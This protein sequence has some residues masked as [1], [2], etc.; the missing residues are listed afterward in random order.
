MNVHKKVLKRK[1]ND[2]KRDEERK[3]KLKRI[4]IEPSPDGNSFVFNLSW[5]AVRERRDE[6]WPHYVDAGKKVQTLLGP[7]V[8]SVN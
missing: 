3:V 6:T 7:P 1:K 5:K 4:E 2:E 8:R